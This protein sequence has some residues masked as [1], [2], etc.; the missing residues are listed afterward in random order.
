MSKKNGLYLDLS[1]YSFTGKSAVYDFITE[2]EGVKALGKEFEFDLFRSRGGILDLYSAISGDWGLVRSSVAVRDFRRA[3]Y[4]LGGHG[5]IIDRFLRGGP[6]YDSHFNNFSELS[7]SYI[8]SLVQA[9]WNGYWPFYD[10]ADGPL[11]IPLKKSI[12]R[13]FNRQSTIEVGRVSSEEF[14]EHTEKYIESIIDSSLSE[15]E[16]ILTVNNSVDPAN[17]MATLKFIKNSKSIIIDRDPR[18]VYLAAKCHEDKDVASAVLGGGIDEFINRFKIIRHVKNEEVDEVDIL[19]ISFESF[20]LQHELEK[21]RIE[22]FIGMDNLVAHKYAGRY[23]SPK[24]SS[25]NI[26]MW[27][28]NEYEFSK[29]I[30]KIENEL[31]EFLVKY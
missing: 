21:K 9:K 31:S 10:Y 30:K 3:I 2:Y 27:K 24:I 25:K 4:F 6:R 28:N 26:G 11:L 18:D 23:F 17:P 1:G 19:R 20:V 12:S 15:S 14:L 16:R 22:D 29:E 5:G 8:D 7:N 13:L